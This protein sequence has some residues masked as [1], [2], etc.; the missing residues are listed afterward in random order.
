MARFAG[1]DRAR[2]R[3]RAVLSPP[4]SACATERRASAFAAEFLRCRGLFEFLWPDTAPAA[5]RGRLPLARPDLQVGHARPARRRAALAPPRREDA[6]ADPRAPQRR[7]RSTAGLETVA[8]D[9]GVFEALRQLD[10]FPDIDEA[11]SPKPPTVDEV[12]DKLESAARRKLAAARATRSG[13][14]S[15]TGSKRSAGPARLGAALRRVPQAAA[16]ARPAARRG[17]A[18]RGGRP[19]RRRSRSST[20]TR[21]R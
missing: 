19:P 9:A 5:D 12:L 20:P 18:G 14:A 8:I 10:L 13:V 16:R 17:R 21:A 2:G 1:I 7:R 11:T 15:P 6:R 4:R 3:V